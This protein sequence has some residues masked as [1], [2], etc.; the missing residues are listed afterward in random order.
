MIAFDDVSFGY[1]GLPV[2]SGISQTLGA[3]GFYF[4]TGPSGS[5][6]T[7]FLHLCTMTR[8]PDSG[9]AQYFGTNGAGLNRDEVAQIRQRMGIVHQ[10]C[11][12][13][14]HLSLR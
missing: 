5:G 1:N 14:D 6:K 13:L 8:S 3:G 4:L 10:D 9:T 12:F 7:T 2:L 11:Q